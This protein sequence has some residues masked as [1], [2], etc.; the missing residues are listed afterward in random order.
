MVVFDRKKISQARS[1]AAA[2]RAVQWRNRYFACVAGWSARAGGAMAAGVVGQLPPEERV[3]IREATQ[4]VGS[5]VVLV[6][7]GRFSRGVKVM[8]A[9]PE[10][11]GCNFTR[12][13]VVWR[14]AGARVS[15]LQC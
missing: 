12:S 1:A 8:G 2:V 13:G 9:R 5:V 15:G 4:K 10:R 3:V 7:A 11:K 6:V 14:G